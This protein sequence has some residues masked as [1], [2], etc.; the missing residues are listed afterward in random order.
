[1]NHEHNPVADRIAHLCQFWQEERAKK[2]QA[3]L[4]RWLVEAADL[5]LIDGFFRVESSSHGSVE[6]TIVAM[7]TNFASSATYAHD[8]SRH[9]LEA[10]QKDAAHDPGLQWPQ[11]ESL[12]QH[13]KE[14]DIRDEEQTRYFFLEVLAGFKAC[15]GKT[16]PVFIGL[17]PQEVC[18][19]RDLNRWLTELTPLLPE[20]IG[21]VLVDFREKGFL[22]K[23]FT[24]MEEEG[25]P[26]QT[27]E[28]K[29]QDM[30]GVYDELMTQED[31]ND[32]QV[33]FRNCLVQMGK[34]SKAKNVTGVEKWG[35]R[36]LEVSQSTGDTVFWAA[37]HM[38]YA[39]FLFNMLE[40]KRITKLLDQGIR[41]GHSGNL[42][43]EGSLR[44]VTLQLY[45]FRAAY[46]QAINKKKEAVEW[47]RKQVH[48]AREHREL[49][50]AITGYKSL[51]MITEETGTEGAQLVSE[52]FDYGWGL[53]DDLLKATEFAFIAG[54]ETRRLAFVKGSEEKTRVIEARMR[55]LFGQGWD[56][57]LKVQIYDVKEKEKMKLK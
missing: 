17:M 9:F 57:P 39:G 53:D 44:A 12:N 22:D 18:S 5:P 13:M 37:A 52:A 20:N 33:I 46:F 19:Y 7:L 24:K 43:K 34:A 38:A 16:T 8:L 25:C 54:Y 11:F 32:P 21:F 48:L 27:L 41:I 26:V 45:G 15:E 2:P 4:I 56:Q 49:L 40:T 6:E 36:A 28:L 50:F 55:E 23:V 1:M 29:N 51:L 47:Y 3:R 30:A 35:D 10:W 31:S 42:E 14:L